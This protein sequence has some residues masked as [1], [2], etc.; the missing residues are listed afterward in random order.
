[1]AN[2]EWGLL[3]YQRAVPPT[4][5][6]TN[7]QAT[8]LTTE[9]LRRNSRQ[10]CLTSRT[11]T[12]APNLTDDPSAIFY[13]EKTKREI[14]QEMTTEH[15]EIKLSLSAFYKLCPKNFKKARKMTDMCPVC[16]AGKKVE[17]KLN[18]LRSEPLNN[19]NT[20]LRLS[21]EMAT[22]KYHQQ[23]K[24]TQKRMYNESI[25]HTTTSACVVTMDFKENFKIGGGP[26]ETGN[27]FYSRTQVSVL[28]FAIHYR[29]NDNNLKIHYIDYFSPI[30]SHDSLFVIDCVKQLMAN[31]FMAQFTQVCFWS[32]SGP[33]FRS[34]EILHFISNQLPVLFPKQ[35]WLN[36]FTEYHGKSIVDGHFGILSRWF[37]EGESINYISN[38]DDLVNFFKNKADTQANRAELGEIKAEFHIYTRAEER[39]NIHRMIIDNCHAFMS[40][41]KFN[42][43]LFAST[44]STLNSTGYIEISFKTQVV[45]DRRK[46]KYAPKRQQVDTDVPVVMGPRSKQVILTRM[47]LTHGNNL[48]HGTMGT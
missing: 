1:L 5:K 15:P 38:I 40:F 2:E 46:T 11:T 27:V 14:Y 3:D 10:S 44:V 31:P 12:A 22:F 47:Q 4:R 9:Y 21:N 13:L 39:G 35:F 33:H 36:Y 43:K 30:L 32:D 41:V 24:E 6:P 8:L 19:N 26:I 18:R 20:I 25:Q 34:A 7:R 37:S 45:K 42:D 48:F 28:A 16:V 29:D 23:S 17:Q